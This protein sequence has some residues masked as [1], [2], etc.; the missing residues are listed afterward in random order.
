MIKIKS[1]VFTLLYMWFDSGLIDISIC[2]LS[3]KTSL[4]EWALLGFCYC[5]GNIFIMIF[6]K[7]FTIRE[8][9]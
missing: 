4:K 9:E 1:K 7:E 8:V 2:L 6:G 3:D 5:E